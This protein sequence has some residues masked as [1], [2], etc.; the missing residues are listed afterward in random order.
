VKVIAG[1]IIAA[2]ATTTAMITGLVELEFYKLKLGQSF[3]GQTGFYNANFNLSVP[4][5]FQFFEPEAAV[6]HEDRSEFDEIMYMDVTTKCYPPRW[7]SWDKL[8]VNE[9]DI[10]IDEF[11]ARFP[12]LFWGVKPTMLCGRA[13][14]EGKMLYTNTLLSTKMEEANLARDGI[15]DKQ[16]KM[17][18]DA[19]ER[20]RKAN[21]KI[22]EGW[23][24]PMS[25]RY[26][27]QYG[28]L[29]P[30]KRNYVVLVGSFEDAEGN[31]AE[32]PPIK[33]IFK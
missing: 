11:V 27:E 10:S 13:V 1:K 26:Q 22:S 25:V 19:L 17:Y 30:A 16:R 31:A 2:L 7:T 32:L 24:R 23:D 3:I 18:E 12:K 20:K 29:V 8:V 6:Q 21:E 15:T 14:K 9:G 5:Q 28:E 33:F 4:T